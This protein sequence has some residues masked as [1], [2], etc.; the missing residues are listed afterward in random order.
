ML[1]LDS[2]SIQKFRGLR[3]IELSQLGRINILVGRN[4]CGKTSVLEALATYAQPLRPSEWID[5]VRRREISNSRSVLIEGLSWLFPHDAFNGASPEPLL[6]ETRVTGKGSSPIREVV[7]SF[8]EIEGIFEDVESNQVNTDEEAFSTTV[9]RKGAR[10]ELRAKVD[11][12]QQSFFG[13]I[14]NEYCFSADIWESGRGPIPQN[15]SSPSIRMETITPFSHR[16]RNADIEAISESVF[17]DVKQAVIRLL[18]YFDPDIVDLEIL[19]KQRGEAI[20]YVDHR[21][22]G[23]TPLSTFG[24]GMRRALIIGA[25]LVT[26]S[27]GILLVDEIE[28]AIHVEALKST[29]KWLHNACRD[30]NVQ[31]FASTHSLEAIDALIASVQA[32]DDLVMYRLERSNGEAQVKRFSHETL[33]VIR[34]ELGLEIRS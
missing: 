29:F 28:S 20:V 34:E 10:L 33:S 4:N 14:P 27:G 32:P 19:K 12:G 9:A 6:R 17:S 11:D 31:L 8:T 25:T 18:H 21:R 5:A 15:I 22:L 13:S 3:N 24:D 16:I 1:P 26:V 30:M 2:F 23:L 7:G